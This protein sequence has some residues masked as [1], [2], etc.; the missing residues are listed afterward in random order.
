M[1]ND[2]SRGEGCSR[3]TDAVRQEVDTVLKAKCIV[4]RTDPK[5]LKTVCVFTQNTTQ[6]MMGKPLAQHSAQTVYLIPG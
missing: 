6:G 5:K 4:E 2:G 1:K 3:L